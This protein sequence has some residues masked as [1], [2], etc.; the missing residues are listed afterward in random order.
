[1]ERSSVKTKVR[2]GGDASNLS[3]ILR[4]T[5]EFKLDD[6]GVDK[7]Y[8]AL[9]H[10]VFNSNAFGTRVSVTHVVDR[11]QKPFPGGYRDILCLLRL[12]GFVCD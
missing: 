6:E 3:D 5:L 9:E 10:L 4:A 2:Y 7:M 8:G 12:N 1:M 11:F